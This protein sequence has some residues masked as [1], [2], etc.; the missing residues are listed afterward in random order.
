M[1]AAVAV[2]LSNRYT[3]RAPARFAPT[4]PRDPSRPGA[5]PRVSSRHRR[6]TASAVVRLPCGTRGTVACVANISGTGTRGR[7][8]RAPP[9]RARSCTRCTPSRLPSRLPPERSSSSP[10][11]SRTH[12]P[13]ARPGRRVPV[14]ALAFAAGVRAR[15]W[16][17][18]QRRQ[19]PPE[20]LQRR[21]LRHDRRATREWR[22]THSNFFRTRIAPSVG[23]TVV[24]G[25]GVRVRQA[26]P[27][28][29]ACHDSMMRRGA[30]AR[31]PGPMTPAGRMRVGKSVYSSLLCSA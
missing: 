24:R 22:R 10:P 6:G 1:I 26:L 20:N 27:P 30:R 7:K 3:L 4:D 13:P 29:L 25:G 11:S 23:V 16:C 19:P 31:V 28:R 15:H 5:A 12:P 8:E 9:A 14:S 17:I 2:V 21:R 18:V